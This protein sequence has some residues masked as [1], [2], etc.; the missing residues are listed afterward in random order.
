[1][2]FSKYLTET[3]GRGVAWAYQFPNWHNASV[4]VDP[5][6]PFRFEV[7]SSDP[8]DKN[9]GW[10]VAGLTSE[11]VEAKLEKLVGLPAREAVA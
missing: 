8:D 6:T 4:I 3:E 10:L 2:D 1:M 9:V 11:Q 5:R 7:L